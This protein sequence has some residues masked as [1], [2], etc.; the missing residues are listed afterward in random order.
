MSLIPLPEWCSI[1]LNNS[2]FCQSL[3]SHHLIVGGIVH[4][5]NDSGLVGDS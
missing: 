4:Y 3:G 1:N 5:I 2:V